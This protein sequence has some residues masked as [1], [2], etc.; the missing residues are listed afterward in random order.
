MRTYVRGKKGNIMF[1]IKAVILLPLLVGLAGCASSL[2]GDTYTRGQTR[3]AQNVQMATVE[4]VREVAIEGTR[5][6][7]GAGAGTIIGGVAGANSNHG[8]VGSTV[9]SVIGAVA[10]G[11]LGAS[12][13]EGV[14]RQTGLEITIKYDDGRMVAVVQGNNED[15]KAGDRV[16]VLNGSGGARITH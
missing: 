6:G 15:F 2:D 8:R 14:T 13:E 10:G 3:Q 1:K 16:R 7:I 5:S 12:A 11:V 9:L 4:S